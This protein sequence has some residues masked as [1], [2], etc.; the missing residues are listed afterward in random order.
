LNELDIVDAADAFAPSGP[1]FKKQ[2]LLARTGLALP[3]IL[4]VA[5]NNERDPQLLLSIQIKTWSD[6]PS[7][8]ASKKE[9]NFGSIIENTCRTHFFHGHKKQ[10]T[11]FEEYWKECLSE[12]Q[13]YHLRIVICWAGFTA[14]QK[15]LVDEF[16]LKQPSQPIALVYPTSTSNHI[17][18]TAATVKLGELMGNGT[19]WTRPVQNIQM[20]PEDYEKFNSKANMPLE[21]NEIMLSTIRCNSFTNMLKT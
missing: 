12:N 14:V 15:K 20:T 21:P 13:I 1:L 10:Q 19:P 4:C 2:V 17:Y 16:N 8:V 18:G 9:D 7:P 3:D 6:R 5:S 11:K